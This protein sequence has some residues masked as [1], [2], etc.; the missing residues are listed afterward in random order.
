MPKMAN[1]LSR[2][3]R[4]FGEGNNSVR[5]ASRI[6]LFYSDVT[7]DENTRFSCYKTKV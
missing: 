2:G 1:K 6:S 5:Q 7:V 3:L 4:T